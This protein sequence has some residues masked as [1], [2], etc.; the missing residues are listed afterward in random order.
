MGGADIK[1]KVNQVP[2]IQKPSFGGRFE[3]SLDLIVSLGT[4]RNLRIWQCDRG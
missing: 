3:E 4:G 2:E 1:L